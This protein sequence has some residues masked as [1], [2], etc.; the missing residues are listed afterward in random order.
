MVYYTFVLLLVGLIAGFL[1]FAGV[2]EIAVQIAGVL[3]VTEM[4]LELVIHLR[5]KRTGQVS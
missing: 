2:L 5:E 3:F 1:G 4:V